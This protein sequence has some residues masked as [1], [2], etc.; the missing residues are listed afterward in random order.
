MVEVGY[1]PDKPRN[2]DISNR[3][4]LMELLRDNKE[5]SHNNMSSDGIYLVLFFF[6]C[7]IIP[8]III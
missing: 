4:F 7:L 1:L 3:L 6:V 5:L 8:L 2:E